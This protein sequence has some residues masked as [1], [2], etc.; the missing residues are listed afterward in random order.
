M[1]RQESISSASTR[2][3][4]IV[5]PQPPSLGGS[6]L[7]VQAMTNELAQCAS[8]R[9]VVINTSPYRDQ[10]KKMTG[11]NA[12]KVWRMIL[13]V[14]KY[15]R[16]LGQSDAVLV[17]ANNLFTST[18]VPVLL[19][20]ARGLHK[21]FYLKPVGGDLDLY[22]ADR[23]KLHRA[24]LLRILRAADGVLAQ[25]ELLR[26]AL[27]KWGC[28]NAYYLPGCRSLPPTIETHREKRE[29]LRLIFL[30]LIH[31]DKGPLVLLEALQLLAHEG[32]P[33]VSC[34]FYGP[35]H[36]EVREAFLRAL[37]ATPNA[38]H[39]GVV[40]AGGASH[41]I[42]AYDVLVLPTH[43]VGEGH[44]G[45]IIEAMHVGVPV[46]STQHRAI[47]ELVS[48]GE[49]GILVPVRDSHALADAIARMAQD[50]AL[51]A[52]MGQA[53]RQRGQQFGAEAVVEQMLEIIFPEESMS[54]RVQPA[55]QRTRVRVRNG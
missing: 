20:L 23:K 52:R 31:R 22:L 8:V 42:A 10:R 50:E 3:L 7:T 13:I 26:A 5:G 38:R 37:E 1:P 14:Q 32:G 51:R 4:L 41:V 17:F 11:F 47:P 44:P 40:E 36:S 25:T 49:N 16:E 9:V 28:T 21:S 12:E 55:M 27:I 30:A 46:I 35:I 48:D 2:T 15:V 33:R 45:V 6:P 39:C 34:D 24:Y 43:F 29:E 18:L 54:A 19:L 53:N